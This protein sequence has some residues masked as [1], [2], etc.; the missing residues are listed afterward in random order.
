MARKNRK[1]KRQVEYE[2]AR[3]NLGQY[4]RR[5]KKAGSIYYADL[6]ISPRKEKGRGAKISAREYRQATKEIKRLWNDLK[7]KR[8]RERELAGADDEY[9]RLIQDWVGEITSMSTN[10]GR[11]AEAIADQVLKWLSSKL[12]SSKDIA[13]AIDGMTAAGVVIS[14]PVYYNPDAAAM[15][16]ASME[17]YILQEQWASSW[18]MQEFEESLFDIENVDYE[19]Q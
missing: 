7:E 11:G 14:W 1:S 17:Q 18:E 13:G 3:K 5:M 8:S 19:L 2:R 12:Y 10:W 15:F 4:I 6:P 9:S 16:I